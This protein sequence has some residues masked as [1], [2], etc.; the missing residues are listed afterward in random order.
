ME[1]NLDSILGSKKP[2]LKSS[3][4]AKIFNVDHSTIFLWV[5]KRKLYPIRTPGGNFRFARAEV[6]RLFREIRSKESERRKSPRFQVYFPVTL[7]IPRGESVVSLDAY[8]KDI[9]D[10]G[11]GILVRQSEEALLNGSVSE[12]TVLNRTVGVFRDI[13]KCAV[14]HA[15]LVGE[16]QIAIGLL[17]SC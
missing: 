1:I 13:V 4:I 3:E 2:Y 17:I 16:N 15:K 11:L 9:S 14:R 6:E 5:K 8:V 7:Q 12:V 10:H